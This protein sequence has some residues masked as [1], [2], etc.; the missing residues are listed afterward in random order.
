MHVDGGSDYARSARDL[1]H[2]GLGI[3]RQRLDG[4]VEDARLAAL[5]VRA[6]GV[7]SRGVGVWAEAIRVSGSA[8]SSAPAVAWAGTLAPR[9]DDQGH[10]AGGD[11]E[12]GSGHERVADPVR[13]RRPDP[14]RVQLQ[15]PRSRS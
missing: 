6:A 5:G 13:K 11:G 15:S 2:A 10:E 1:R 3:V 9:E 12:P 8:W 4:G 14:I 7:A